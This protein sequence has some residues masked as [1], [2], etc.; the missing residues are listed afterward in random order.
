MRRHPAVAGQFYKG[1]PEALR[2]QVREFIV[3]VAVKTKAL[4]IVSPHAGLMYS[5]S[6]AGAVYS[7]VELPDTFVLIGPNHTGL[8]APVSLMAS[9]QWE[10]PLGLVEID[11]ALAASILSKSTRIREDSLAHLHEHSLEVQLPFIQQFKQ[12]FK[13]VP[14]QMLDTR[15]D[16]CKEVGKAIGE[17][18][19]ERNQESGQ[20]KLLTPHSALHTSRDVLIVA[21]SDMSH[22]ER[23]AVAKEKDFKAIHELLNL[24]PEGLY[25]TVRENGIT[26]CGYGPAVTMLIACNL[27]GATRA[28]L[29]KYTNSGDV[30][31]DYEQVVGYAGVV[32]V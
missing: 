6:V 21:S 9:G 25:R 18:V 32:V 11:G 20:D 5:G 7:R 31:G 19:R 23:A 17:A 22:Y 27:L 2:K 14:I 1:S 28:E 29:I 30:S 16:T 24:D 3:A 13:I 26:M 4:G 10:T 8:G 12:E 15:L